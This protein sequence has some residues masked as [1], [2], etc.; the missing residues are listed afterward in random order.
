MK[1]VILAGGQGKRLRPFTE[2][3]PKPLIELAGRPIIEW[4]IL[5]LREQGIR[6]FVVLAGYRRE[7]LIEYL[8]GGK[9]LGVSV[10]FSVED[11][12]LGTAGALKNAA[13]LLNE[14]F[15]VVNGDVITDV[16]VA[17][18]SL[19]GEVASMVLVPLRSPYGVV[20]TKDDH[21][22]RFEEKPLLG[23]Y[24][25]N[26]GVYLMSP[27]V[28]EYLPDKGDLEKTTFPEL[29]SKGLL[30]AVKTHSYWR[31]IDSVKDV[32]EVSR[33]LEEGK[34]LNLRSP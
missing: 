34:V 7:R 11:E 6:S 23:D 16:K 20:Y 24:W 12:P 15:L 18:M 21:V 14:E 3:K 33:D 17:S 32:E 2:D 28:V 25:I 4:Q 30:R 29:A 31:S 27:R 19:N 5:W 8:G 1:A 26:A 13:H 22:V 10:A 9:R